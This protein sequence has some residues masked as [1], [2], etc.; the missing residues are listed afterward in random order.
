MRNHLLR[1][2]SL[3]LVAKVVALT[4]LYFLFFDAARHPPPDAPQ[5]AA[6]VLGQDSGAHAR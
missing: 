1:D 6:W 4:A 2:V 3:A 5:V